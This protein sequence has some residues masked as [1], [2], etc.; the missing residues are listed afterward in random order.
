MTVSRIRELMQERVI[1]E[2][3][4]PQNIAAYLSDEEELPPELDAFTFLNRLRS[5]GIG[6][7]DF[8]YLLK[9][10]G[11]PEEAISKIEQH[12][13]M[14]LQSLIKTLHDSGLTPKDYTRMLYTARQLWEHTITM[15]I[16]LDEIQEEAPQEQPTEPEKPKKPEATENPEQI[17]T[18]RQKKSEPEFHEYVGVKPI[19][20]LSA[21]ELKA[22]F[23]ADFPN[24]QEKK[25]RIKTARQKK[26]SEQEF[27]EYS[28]VKP[29]GKRSLPDAT[30][31]TDETEEPEIYTAVQLK[32]EAEDAEEDTA[33][34]T[35][36]P[37]E[38]DPRG[39]KGGIIAAVCGAALL[40][41]VNV[42][43]G[44]LGFTAPETKLLEVHFAADN[45][46]IFSDIVKA[47]NAERIGGGFV[48]E[49]PENAQIFGDLLIDS[50]EQLG[51]YSSGSTIWAAEPEIVKVY[52]V[53]GDSVEI[54]AEIEPPEGAQFMR[55]QQ[56]EN[57]IS[58]VFSGENS[59]GIAGIDEKGQA[60]LSEQSGT[61]TDIYCT[62]D[63]I[64]LGSVYTPEFTHSF[65]I[66]DVL[67]YLPWTGNSESSNAFSA[68]EIAVSGTAQ[69]CSYAVWAEYT[70]DTGEIKGRTAALGD[71]VFS[72]A[73]SFSAAL[74]A[75]S[76]T[77]LISLGNDKKLQS[78]TSPEIT[79]CASGSGLIATAENSE[80]GMTVYLRD[81]EMNLLG[82]FA[83]GGNITSLRIDGDVIYVCDGEKIIMAADIS[84]PSAPAALELTAAEG[85]ISGE[86]ALCSG[87]TASGITL[88]LYRLEENKAVQADSFAKT[89]TPE[90]LQSFAFCGANTAAVNGTELCGAAY[91]WFDGV[92]VVDEFAVLGKSRSVKTLYDDPYGFTAAVCTDDGL[93][94]I[95]GQRIYK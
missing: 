1:P 37:P 95:C 75:D 94:L 42:G 30:D 47:Y 92:S 9:G 7:A 45:S 56:T 2:S 90:E 50:G 52:A 84:S 20:K 51:V 60:F 61:L 24:E 53:S 78:G 88:T 65:T 39:R 63:I 31:E 68:A 43:V 54:T 10:C 48:Q 71:P 18:A 3:V 11:A 6:S 19:G 13:D 55:I 76:G 32:E 4:L 80:N 46:E 67:D 29:I 79:A 26:S 81:S 74:R 59:C 83:C 5:L 12:P 86:Y 36:T 64:R 22:D 28:G 16:D 25:K 15:R 89:L 34:E 58:A 70:P 82:G 8:L 77:L 27:R 62:A 40:C 87:K 49:M 14:N 21:E 41:A 66:D 38:D 44:L 91:R 35:Q 85:V 57:G 23:D 93:T 33:E 73:E 72:G 17:R 69:G